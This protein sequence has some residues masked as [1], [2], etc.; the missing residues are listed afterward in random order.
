MTED[1]AF[2]KWALDTSCYIVTQKD[3]YYAGYAQATKDIMARWP[4]EEQRIDALADHI[5]QD[6]VDIVTAKTA[7]IG[8]AMAEHWLKSKLFPKDEVG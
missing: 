2:N 1:D 4:S 8:W 6:N 5:H 7:A 3:A